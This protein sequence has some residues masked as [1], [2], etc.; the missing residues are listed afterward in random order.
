MHGAVGARGWH[1]MRHHYAWYGAMGGQV[2]W[3]SRGAAPLLGGGRSQ[4]VCAPAAVISIS[5]TS[6]AGPPPGARHGCRGRERHNCAPY[7]RLCMRL[8]S[9][10]LE[11]GSGLAG[12]GRGEVSQRRRRVTARSR[13][14]GPR[15]I[16]TPRQ[17]RRAPSQ[18]IKIVC[19]NLLRENGGG[20]AVL[21]SGAGR[22][23]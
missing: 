7:A 20:V 15:Q 11:G 4:D 10:G 22:N 3:G 21:V 19:S 1:G 23:R 9:G 12:G 14:R 13:R 6:A 18:K 16:H 8:G 5:V 17:P 2:G